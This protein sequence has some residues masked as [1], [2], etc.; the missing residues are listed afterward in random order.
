[1]IRLGPGDCLCKPCRA[2]MLAFRFVGSLAYVRFNGADVG[3]PF[4]ELSDAQ[5]WAARHIP[6][7]PFCR[8][9]EAARAADGCWVPG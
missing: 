2:R 1:M 7:S 4:A 8:G 5:A 6:V 3:G 9:R